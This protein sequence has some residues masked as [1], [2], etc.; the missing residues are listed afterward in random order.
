MKKIIM[1]LCVLVS[2]LSFSQVGINTNQPKAT[3]DVLSSPSDLTKT[4]GFIAPKLTG[5]ELR[6]KDGLYSSQLQGAIVYATSAAN[7]AS[8]KTENVTQEGYYY[9]DGNKWV[10]FS[11]ESSNNGN[12]INIYKDDGNLT[13]NRNANLNGFNLAFTG[14]GNLGIGTTVVPAEKLEVNGGDAR[15]RQRV[16]IGGN[17]VKNAALGVLNTNA[18]DLILRLTNTSNIRQFSV[19][20]AGNVGI[21]LGEIEPS[22]RLDV[23]GSA[24]LRIVEDGTADNKILVIDNNGVVKKI[25]GIDSSDVN[26]YKDNGTLTSN[27]VIT[28][29]GKNLS[30]QGNGNVGIGTTGNPSE[31]LEVNG[32][33]GIRGKVTIGPGTKNAALGV[34][35]TDASEPIMRLTDTSNVRQ[36]SVGDDGKVGI[37]LGT[38]ETSEKLDVNGNVRLRN[39]PLETEIATTDRVMLLTSNGT[40]KKVSMSTLRSEID[41]NTN[42]YTSNGTLSGDRTVTL[43]GNNLNFGGAGAVGIGVASPTEKLDV[44]GTV[45]LRNIP[46]GNTE[47]RV[48][49]VDDNGVVQKSSLPPASSFVLY[50]TN[51]NVIVRNADDVERPLAFEGTPNKIY[52]DYIEKVN[53]TTYE[54]KKTGVYTAEVIILYDDIPV[55][56]S[57]DTRSGCRA[58]LSMGGKNLWKIGDR[59]ANSGGTTEI[60]RS[61]IL[62][63]GARISV[64]TGC[65]RTGN[66]TYKTNSGSTI[67]ITYMPL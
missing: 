18:S 12:D 19:T 15:F 7:P 31:K 51:N 30:F 38:L 41:T 53:N 20:D 4:D 8:T 13:S 6:A 1:T 61:V 67:F 57:S 34:R 64:E 29:D 17:T 25:P 14:N 58:K 27:R 22:Q 55:V 65:A 62:N 2:T 9:F 16:F 39:V 56:N 11:S 21:G 33:S 43:G 24:R 63:P 28:M 46:N 60:S 59:W 50:D 52:S 40:G 49:V 48:L 45:R 23:W 10:R 42:L 35:N 5:N 3:L 44:S 66:Q 54:V 36:F 32:D 26:I 37:G 47:G